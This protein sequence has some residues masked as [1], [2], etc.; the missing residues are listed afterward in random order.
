MALKPLFR[1]CAAV[2]I[3]SVL[4]AIALVSARATAQQR[5][6]FP[7]Q[8]TQ[9]AGTDIG[10]PAISGPV[11]T[12]GQPTW[13]P[14][15][16]G[17]LPPA[18]TTY[19]PPAAGPYAAPPAYGAPGPYAQPYAAPAPYYT[20]NTTTPGYLYP[21]GTPTYA[22]PGWPMGNPLDTV[23]GWTKFFQEIRF[24]ETYMYDHGDRKVSFN[25]FETSATF[26]IPPGWSASPI[27]LTPG[28]GLHLWD[29]PPS[30]GPGSADLPAQTYDAFLDTAWDPQ[31]S[32]YFGAELGVRVGV[33][34]DFHTI[35][36]HSLREM[37]R[38]LGVVNISP[39][40]QLKLGV[41]YIDRI[42]IKL[43]PAG[44]VIWTPDPDTRLELFFPRPKITHRFNTTGT[45]QWWWYTT[46]EYGGGSWTIQRAAGGSDQ[47]DYDDIEIS[48]G[49]EWVPEASPTALR[50]Y[51]EYGTALERDLYYRTFPPQH[52]DLR[53]TVYVRAGISF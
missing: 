5:I 12:P 53:P 3:A 16:D 36:S 37:G 46:A 11:V 30:H 1:R 4:I 15:A 25:D 52:V 24:Q 34:S 26:A 14:Y 33:Y 18:G 38:G 9:P 8:L 35:N 49:I 21:N 29:G 2:R 19:V 31:F 45:Y 47:F 10:P 40:L 39:T 50:G 27:L 43:L 6:L 28:F 51:L 17:G 42:H 7:T 48:S 41:V 13:D 44:G 20:P 22:G 23:N 32:P